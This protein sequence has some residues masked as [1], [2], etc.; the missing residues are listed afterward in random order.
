[1]CDKK[2]P[3]ILVV[4]SDQH[5]RSVTGCYG[6]SVIHTPN[7]DRLADQG[8]CFDNTYCASPLCVPSRM[9]FM[10]GRMPSR[11]RIWTNNGILSSGTPTWAHALGSAGYLTALI[12]RMHFVGTDQ[13]HGFEQRPIGEGCARF[14]GVSEAGGPRYTRFPRATAGQNRQLFE[15]VGRGPNFNQDYGQQVTD[16]T[17]AFLHDQVEADRP[18]AAVVGYFLPHSPFVGQ[19]Q[20]FDHYLDHVDT[21]T[22]TGEEPSCIEALHVWRNLKPPAT[23]QQLRLARAAYYAMVQ[24]VDSQLGQVLNTLDKTGLSQNT[25]VIYCSDHGEMLGMHGLWAKKCFYEQA[26]GVPLIARLPGM[27]QPGSRCETICNL[28]DLASTFAQLAGNDDIDMDGQSLLPLMQGENQPDRHTISEV[29]DVQLHRGIQWLGHA[30]CK[31]PWKLWQHQRPDGHAWEPVLLNLDVDPYEQHNLANDPKHRQKRDELLALLNQQ[32][33]PQSIV[34]EVE[35][36]AQDYCR[37]AKWGSTL[38]PTCVDTYVWPG[39][40]FEDDLELIST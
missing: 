30:I 27:I 25:L 10:T 29:V 7:M 35:Q 22:Y 36:Q 2:S 40:E 31:G 16:E 1:M 21:K 39:R 18:F 3:N 24:A 11:N 32:W 26:M 4:M 38:Q 15:Y 23:K 6:D 5:A 33:E 9:S 14:P 37:L 34:T 17:C 28:I 20:L 8:M 19:E 12:G 13:R